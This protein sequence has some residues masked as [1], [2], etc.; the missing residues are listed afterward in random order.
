MLMDVKLW[1]IISDLVLLCSSTGRES[2][3]FRS[4]TTRASLK[5]LGDVV[6][7]QTVSRL[8][9]PEKF[10]K[11]FLPQL[12]SKNEMSKPARQVHVANLEANMTKLCQN[13]TNTSGRSIFHA[14][15]SACSLK[16]H[17]ITLGT[18]VCA[19]FVSTNVSF[20][21]SQVPNID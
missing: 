13:S 2:S 10:K 7:S 19:F 3:S 8:R 20:S 6:T 11:S 17:R 15:S 9:S 1:L 14:R 18:G 21:L 12:V 4:R 16:S 5:D